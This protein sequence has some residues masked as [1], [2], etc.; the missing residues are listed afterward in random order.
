MNIL[1]CCLFLNLSCYANDIN[2]TSDEIVPSEVTYKQLTVRTVDDGVE[3]TIDFRDIENSNSSDGWLIERNSG[4]RIQFLKQDIVK[5]LYPFTQRGV[6]ADFWL[7]EGN[8]SVKIIPTGGIGNPMKKAFYDMKIEPSYNNKTSKF[9]VTID[10][11]TTS[12][13]DFFD[14]EFV[15]NNTY[16]LNFEVYVRLGKRYGGTGTMAASYASIGFKKPEGVSQKNFGNCY[17]TFENINKKKIITDYYNKN[18]FSKYDNSCFATIQARFIKDKV[19]Y[20]IDGP[21]SS[22]YSLK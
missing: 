11:N 5:F 6:E 9:Y 3:I 8:I 16:T 14:T 10:S 15:I 17:Y 2:S 21:F 1:I 13:K 20:Y 18:D 22:D 19:N 7:I 4:I 12:A